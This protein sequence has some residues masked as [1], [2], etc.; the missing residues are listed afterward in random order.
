M[1]GTGEE[2]SR[3]ARS[4]PWASIMTAMVGCRWLHD[5]P[6]Q[7]YGFWGAGFMGDDHG[8]ALFVRL[9]TN[10]SAQRSGNFVYGGG[11][12]DRDWSASIQLVAGALEQW[13]RY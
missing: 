12:D 5:V 10:T 6:H 8:Q 11:D 9:R 4:P 3:T 1:G 7:D 2:R 13:K